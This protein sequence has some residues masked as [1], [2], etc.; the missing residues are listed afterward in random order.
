[1][2]GHTGPTS[3]W[4]EAG[5]QQLYGETHWTNITL[6]WGRLTTALWGDTL[7]QHHSGLRQVDNSSMGRHTGPTSLWVE[8]GWQQLYGETHWTNI[9]LG[10]GRLTTALWGDTLDQHHSGLKQVDNSSMGGHTGPT[11]HWVEAGWLQLY[12]ET[13]WTNITLGWG[14]LTTA[15][16]GDTLYQHHSG[17]RQ[18]DNSSMG[19]YTEP[20]SHWVEAGWQL[21]YGGTHW[22]NITLGWSRLTIA[23]WGDTLDQHHTGL[24]QV[25]YSS[26][27][28]HT[29]PTSHWVEAGW[30][31]TA[32]WGD[33][34][35]QHHT[36]LKQVDNSSMGRHTGPTSLWV[37]AGWQQLYG[38][39][40]WTKITLGWGRLTT[41]LWGDTLYQH[42]SGL[43]QVD[44][45]SM[46]RHTEPTSH[47][48]EAGWQQLYGET[49]WTNITLGWGRLITAL[50]RDTLNQHHTRLRQ[51]DNS[52][53]GRHTGPTSYWVE[54]GWQQLYG[55]TH[56]TNITLGWGRLTTALWGDTLDQ[57]HTGL[58]QVDNSSMGRHTV[59]TS[60]WVEAGWLQLYGETHWTNITLGWGRL[61][62][63]LWGDTL[64][65]HHTGLRQV[66]YSSME[67]HTGP[68][69]H[70][71]EAGWL[72][73]YGDTHW[74]NITLGWGR[75]TTALWR[76]TLN[77]HH[78][79]LR[80]VDN[81][82]MGRHTGPTSH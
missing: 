48:V 15:L 5:W 26:M 46:G 45:S 81:S 74:T 62:T 50:W 70:W 35:Y 21:L 36:G 49:H 7:D 69:S 34:L 75:L 25:D 4:V 52:S 13:H 60:L 19:R 63:A 47:W 31:T 6:G 8:A 72:Q 39:T 64:D 59:P 37:E 42:H 22:T 54:V 18:V 32:L 16:W 82:S 10:W 58:R 11:S 27:G 55:E 44:Y 9:T 80:Q 1:M 14:R 66:D 40:H 76:D 38:E 68:T 33:T 20:T 24:R 77:Q 3:L 73:L 78:T 41:A 57:H 2:G 17:L 65:Q 79:R 12:V 67:G 23:L 43:R 53:M 29:G 30:Q 61:T 51:V 71:D 56:W 28:R